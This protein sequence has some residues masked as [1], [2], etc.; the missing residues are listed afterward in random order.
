MATEDNVVTGQSHN[1]VSTTIGVING[2]YFTKGNWLVVKVQL[3][4]LAINSCR[5]NATGVTE[6]QIVTVARLNIIAKATADDN[7]VSIS[8]INEVG[9][10]TDVGR[11]T[12]NRID[13]S[14]IG[15]V[16]ITQRLIVIVSNV[17][18]VTQ[19]D[20]VIGCIIQSA[21]VARRNGIAF[22]TAYDN[23]SSDAGI[24]GVTSTDVEGNGF[25]P[26]NRQWLVTPPWSIG[27]C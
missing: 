23:V 4:D 27:Y 17:A 19:D 15:K 7:V 1:C 8:G 20:I 10:A 6:D 24:D 18:C 25:D 14:G 16:G 21:E 9:A 3:S 22:V 5:C 12:D 2:L 26:A 11:K 13:I